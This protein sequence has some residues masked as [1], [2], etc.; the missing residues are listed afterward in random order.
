[1]RVGTGLRRRKFDKCVAGTRRKFKTRR[2]DGGGEG[3]SFAGGL[4]HCAKSDVEEE[5]PVRVELTAATALQCSDD[6]IGGVHAVT[7]AREGVATTSVGGESGWGLPT[8][9]SYNETPGCN[10]NI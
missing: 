9:D 6:G 4:G 5:G 2:Q 8:G 3:A 10:L 1:M 7:R